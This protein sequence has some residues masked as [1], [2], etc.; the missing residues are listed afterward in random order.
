MEPG[1]VGPEALAVLQLWAEKWPRGSRMKL[2]VCNPYVTGDREHQVS[3][4]KP[5]F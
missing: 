3:K 1:M 2:T 5:H 4:L